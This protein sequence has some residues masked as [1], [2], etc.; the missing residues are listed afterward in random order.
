MCYALVC[1]NPWRGKRGGAKDRVK[2][3]NMT[4][5]VNT[6][7][8]NLTRTTMLCSMLQG[9]IEVVHRT[10]SKADLFKN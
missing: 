7:H 9:Y 2:Y 10:Y 6:V 1:V 8:T 5:E 4:R 3:K